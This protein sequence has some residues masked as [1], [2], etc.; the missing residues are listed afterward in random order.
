VKIKLPPSTDSKCN[1]FNYPEANLELEI[2]FFGCEVNLA[3]KDEKLE[4]CLAL[5]LT[6]KEGQI[7]I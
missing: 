4:D 2:R 1:P 6:K 7:M 5:I 3:W